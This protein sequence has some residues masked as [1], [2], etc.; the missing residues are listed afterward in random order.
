MQL[1]RAKPKI[2]NDPVHGFISIPDGILFELTE[3]PWFQRL[4]RIKQLSLTHLVYP[5]ALHTRFHHALGATHLMNLAIE[6][7]QLKGIEIS[8]E[9]KEAALIAI[10]LHD[11]G[12]GPYSHTLENSITGEISHEELSLLF[13]QTLNHEFK[14]QLD[15]AIQI[16]TNKYPKRFLHLLVSGQL[17]VDRLDYLKRD[18]F[19]TG[20]AEGVISTERLISMLDVADDELVI[21]AKGIYSVEKFLIA[22]RLMY[23][24]V[25]LH[26]TVMAAEYMLI[27]ALK[28]ARF[29]VQN[30][31]NLFC[32]PTFGYFLRHSF[33]SADFSQIQDLTGQFALLDDHDVFQAIKVWCNHQ[34]KVL[35]ILCNGLVNRHLFRTEMRNFS[36]TEQEIH[37]LQKQI[38]NYYDIELD[39]SAFLFY[40]DIVMNKAY[41]P[42]N[43]AIKILQKNGETVDI[44][45]AAG[46]LI[47]SALSKPVAKYFICYP[48]IFS[49]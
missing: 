4:R 22:R 18:S 15:K 41:N 32:S 8:A 6:T 24:Q 2:I 34:D 10:L 17:D 25:Y 46:Q 13:M 26:K 39:E 1:N 29:L 40:H 42:D 14:N 44:S 7:L 23:W 45:N 28:R 48:K 38:S 43:E 11:T 30:G 16:F 37:Q 36:W 9:E 20:V 33:S 27:L 49:Q 5:G 31:E 35:S 47:I 12:H 3:H 21:E 19:Y